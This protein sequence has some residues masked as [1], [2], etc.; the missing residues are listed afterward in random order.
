MN[1]PDQPY[2]QALTESLSRQKESD[3]IHF[4]DLSLTTI[5]LMGAGE[6]VPLDPGEQPIGHF[7]FAVTD[8][9]HGTAPNRRYV[10]L[11]IQ[12][13]VKTLSTMYSVPIP[14]KNS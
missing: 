3:P 11:I 5:K 4:P 9:T 8:Y 6:Y 2:T 7:A 1:L 10:D 12:R 13:L 14:Q